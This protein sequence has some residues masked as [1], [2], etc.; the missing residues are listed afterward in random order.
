M[1]WTWCVDRIT[2]CVHCVLLYCAAP[3]WLL[4]AFSPLSHRC[5]WSRELLLSEGRAAVGRRQNSSILTIHLTATQTSYMQSYGIGLSRWSLLLSWC[6]SL[7]DVAA[8]QERSK[9][10]VQWF[11]PWT[12]RCCTLLHIVSLFVHHKA[13]SSLHSYEF[14]NPLHVSVAWIVITNLI[15]PDWLLPYSVCWPD[16]GPSSSSF[17]VWGARFISDFSGNY[18]SPKYDGSLSGTRSL[19]LI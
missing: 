1:S 14:I 6:K 12:A 7:C 11:F 13:Q 17:L 5:Y 4:N 2:Q 10:T 15:C 9:S 8:R 19:L 3:Y 18:L 16:L